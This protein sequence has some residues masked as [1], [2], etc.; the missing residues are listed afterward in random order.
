[1][2]S[3]KNIR[4]G[5]RELSSHSRFE[6]GM[7]PKFDYGMMFSVGIKLSR[8]IF[9]DLF[10]IACFKYAVAAYHFE[11]SSASHQWNT[12][13]LIAAH[14]RE[15]NLFTSL[16]TLLYSIRVRQG[17]EDRLY[18]ISSRRELFDVRPYYNVLVPHDNTPFP[19]RNIWRNKAPLRVV[20]LLGRS[21]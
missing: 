17:G 16:F 3:W 9:L 6:T 19:L 8:H 20:S 14:D 1:M 21:L 18:W 15:M 12:Y 7:T 11:L 10:S 2:G 4:R 5:Q 13:F